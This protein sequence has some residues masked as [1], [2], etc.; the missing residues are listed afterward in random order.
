[1]QDGDVI[2]KTGSR[3]IATDKT[4]VERLVLDATTS[5][6]TLEILV[7]VDAELAVVRKVGAPST[8]SAVLAHRY[9]PHHATCLVGLRRSFVSS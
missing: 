2:T 7:T 8:A 6:L 1:L 5:E 4:V 3:V 9:P